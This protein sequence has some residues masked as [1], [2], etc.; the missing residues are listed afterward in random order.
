MRPRSLPL[1]RHERR[2]QGGDTKGRFDISRSE[3]GICRCRDVT[4]PSDEYARAP[5]QKDDAIRANEGGP[6]PVSGQNLREVRT[7]RTPIIGTEFRLPGFTVHHCAARVHVGDLTVRIPIVVPSRSGKCVLTT[8]LVRGLTFDEACAA[9]EEQRRAWAETLWRFV[10]KG[11][12]FGGHFNADP[13]PGNYIFHDGGAVTF[14]DYG[15]VQP[16]DMRT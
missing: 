8:E 1:R 4:G 13:H 16:I 11:N 12:L 2:C 9:P 15:C 14:L 10:F 5:R 7:G 6:D 3:G